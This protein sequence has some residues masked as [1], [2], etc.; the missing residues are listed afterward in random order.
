[1]RDI[2]FRGKRKDNGEWVYGFYYEKAL[3]LNPIKTPEDKEEEKP[4]TFIIFAGFAD[5]NMPRPMYQVEIV[6]ETLGQYT[7][8][9]D[10][11][12]HEIYEGMVV[13]QV[14]VLVSSP[15]IDFTGEVKFYDG[16]WYIDNG[17][18]AVLL[19]NETCENTIVKERFK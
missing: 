16:S 4:Q 15:D 17:K 19:F 18:D 3:P 13:H 11:T 10:I 2:K 14:S 6:P 8:Q 12:E 5:W 7:E 9:K 1:M